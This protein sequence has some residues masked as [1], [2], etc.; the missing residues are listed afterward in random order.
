MRR[1]T[2][3]LRQQVERMPEKFVELRAR[4][5]QVRR[6]DVAAKRRLEDCDRL[7]RAMQPEQGSRHFQVHPREA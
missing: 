3:P 5:V 2:V 6:V 4:H 1:G 7:A